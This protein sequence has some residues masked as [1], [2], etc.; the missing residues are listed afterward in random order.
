MRPNGRKIL[1]HPP[2]TRKPHRPQARHPAARAPSGPAGSRDPCRTAIRPLSG[3]D[4]CGGLPETPDASTSERDAAEK[5]ADRFVA[6]AARAVA[7]HAI[8]S[9]VAAEI[10]ARCRGSPLDAEIALRDILF[11]AGREVL[12]ETF[13][14]LDDYGGTVEAG[15]ETFR[16]TAAT[17]GRAGPGE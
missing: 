11:S 3:S 4:L 8:G 5:T 7:G 13:G 1:P 14:Q 2:K 10:A 17:T 16:K 12:A 6:E 9:G 15:G